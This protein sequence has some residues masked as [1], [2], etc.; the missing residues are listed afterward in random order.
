MASMRS[1]AM[2]CLVGCRSHQPVRPAADAAPGAPVCGE[3]RALRPGLT[4]E[5]IPDG[6]ACITLV[7]IAPDRFRLRLLTAL[8]DGGPRPAPAWADGFGLSAVINASMFHP[9]QRS[10]GL[11]VSGAV[12]N[13]PRDN[14]RL[15]AYFAFDPVD[16]ADTPWILVGRG[17][18]GVDP[19]DLRRRYRTV[20]QNYRMLDCAGRPVDWKDDKKHS[21]AAVGVDDV[22]RAVFV[23]SPVLHRVAEHMQ[24]LGAPALGLKSLMYVEGGP[25]ASLY[26]RTESGEVSEMGRLEVGFSTF[27]SIP[28]VIGVVEKN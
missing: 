2:V 24:L 21:A 10:I 17:C 27:W 19:T 15:G 16:P 28:N 14:P 11:L 13:N 23:L 4:V 3:K 26:V 6:D 12:E 8:S 18:A 20:V 9:D 7:R 25:E 1:W 22:G 5:R